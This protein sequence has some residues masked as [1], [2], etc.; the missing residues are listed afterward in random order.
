MFISKREFNEAIRKAVCEAEEKCWRAFEEERKH[1]YSNERN[2]EIER[3]LR[4]VEEKCGLVEPVT[5]Y[6]CGMVVPKPTI[7]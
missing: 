4:K 7:I 5:T 1:R 2:D 6:P 3:R